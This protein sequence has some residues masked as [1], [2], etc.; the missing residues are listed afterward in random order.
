[1]CIRDS[2][3]TDT[4][5]TDPSSPWG[6]NILTNGGGEDG[7][8]TGWTILEDGGDGWSV[9]SS[10]RTGDHSFGTSYSSCS[11]EQVLDLVALG[12]AEADLDAAPDIHISEW[13]KERYRGGDSYALT[14]ELIDAS[15][16]IITSHET[17]GT[18]TGA[19]TYDDD[20]WF[21][22]SATLSDYGSGLRSIRWEDS[23]DDA[24][25]WAGHYGIYM[26]DASLIIGDASP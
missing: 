2:T 10:G 6:V 4:D 13:F 17:S 14:V 19:A 21:E 24:E 3:D 8:M 11:K 20:E 15:G 26:D 22:V 12:F 9:A 5:I 16:S 7:D 18:T 1:M 25:F 23:G